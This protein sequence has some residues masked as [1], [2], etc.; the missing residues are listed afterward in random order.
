MVPGFR[1]WQRWGSSSLI[2][3]TGGAQGIG[4]AIVRVCAAEGAKLVIV[5]RDAKE[6]REAT[7]T[8]LIQRSLGGNCGFVL[9]HPETEE[10]VPKVSKSG[11]GRR[12]RILKRAK[13]EH[14]FCD[15]IKP[16]PARHQVGRA[17]Y[18]PRRKQGWQKYPDQILSGQ[19]P[20]SQ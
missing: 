18:H 15:E 8:A 3:V 4:A 1:F 6:W 9:A 5:D 7:G 12:S 13:R 19:A 11:D 16:L 17:P 14:L 10:G 20:A 2:L